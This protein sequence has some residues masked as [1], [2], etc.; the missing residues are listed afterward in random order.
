MNRWLKFNVVGVVGFALQSAALFVLTHTAYSISYLAATAVAVELAVL[1]N[2]AWHQRWTWSDRPATTTRQTLRR[3]A[4][5]NLTTG[6]VSIAG[7]L[8]LM[9]ILVGRFGLPVVGANVVTVVACSLISFVFADR[10]A[11]SFQAE[12]RP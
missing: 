11:F 10:I 2:F 7:N 5:F 9:S 6:L 4:T 1:N 3:L 12:A 8:I